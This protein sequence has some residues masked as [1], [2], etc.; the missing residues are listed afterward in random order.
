M[1]LL[2]TPAPLIVFI[3]LLLLARL[4][5]GGK[6]PLEWRRAFLAA[7]LAWGLLLVAATEILSALRAFTPLGVA[8]AWSLCGLV[9]ALILW[10]ALRRDPTGLQLRPPQVSGR[11]PFT[12]LALTGLDCCTDP[13]GSAAGSAQQLGLDDL[14][15]GTRDALGAGSQHRL[16]PHSH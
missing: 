15:H 10:R 14:S 6:Q 5:L 3:L 7:S 16:L 2:M 4:R 9:L 1:P 8:L 13:A 12:R 11:D